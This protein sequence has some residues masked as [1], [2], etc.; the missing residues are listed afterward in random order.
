MAGRLQGFQKG[1]DAGRVVAGQSQVNEESVGAVGAVIAQRFVRHRNQAGSP[2][3]GAFRQQLLRPRSERG[4]GGRAQESDFVPSGAGGLPQGRPQFQAGVVRRGPVRAAFPHH[5]LRS[6]QQPGDVHSEQGGR[7]QPEGGQGR[8]TPA[9]VGGGVEHPAEPP[10]SGQRFQAGAGVGD[11]GEA[12]ARIFGQ[13]GGLLP[14]VAE[15]GKG[16]QSAA[17]FGGG[18]KQGAFRVEPGAGRLH[19]RRMGA[20]RHQQ[21]GA[22][23]GGAEGFLKHFRGQAGTAHSQQGNLVELGAG[24]FGEVPPLRPGLGG[25]LGQTQPSQPVG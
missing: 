8:I 5:R 3:A 15:E 1:R 25:G 23:G 19:R 22:A 21:I 2:F 17:R 14:E 12:A 18:Q 11:G 24:L 9:H 16:F 13:A 10:F 7:N 4:Q 20:V 6:R